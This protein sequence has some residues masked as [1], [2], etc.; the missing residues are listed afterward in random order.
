MRK[1]KNRKILKLQQALEDKAELIEESFLDKER[2]RDQKETIELL[3]KRIREFEMARSATNS[4]IGMLPAPTRTRSAIKQLSEDKIQ[5]AR[6]LDRL[7][8]DRDRL[9]KKLIDLK[10]KYANGYMQRQ[11]STASTDEDDNET[12][13]FST[14]DFKKKKQLGPNKKNTVFSA[15]KSW[16]GSKKSKNNSPVKS[17]KSSFFLKKADNDNGVAV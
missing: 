10:I 7:T 2:I 16:F 14:I 8:A 3:T 15:A 17:T 6:E 1:T 5:L 13:V 9:E 4:A 11:T 12:N